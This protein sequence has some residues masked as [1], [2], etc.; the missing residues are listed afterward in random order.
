MNNNKKSHMLFVKKTNKQ[1]NKQKGF[2]DSTRKQT[3]YW[4]GH[5]DIKTAKIYIS[6]LPEVSFLLSTL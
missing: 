3:G 5:P 6:V 2:K 1:T 4:R